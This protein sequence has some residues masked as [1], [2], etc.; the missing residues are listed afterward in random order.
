M[1]RAA[2][3]QVG[4]DAWAIEMR[5]ARRR[6]LAPNVARDLSGDS[7]VAIKRSSAHFVVNARSAC[8]SDTPGGCSMRLVEELN[9]PFLSLQLLNYVPRRKL[10]IL[11]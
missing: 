11:I 1:L 6:R 5:R 3:T 9:Q 8:A 2:Q 4:G 7:L 10:T